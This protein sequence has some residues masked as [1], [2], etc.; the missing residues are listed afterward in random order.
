MVTHPEP[1]DITFRFLVA[2]NSVVGSTLQQLDIGS[3]PTEKWSQSPT[4]Q[5]ADAW[6]R[7]YRETFEVEPRGRIIWLYLYIK[8]RIYA[9]TNTADVDERI[10]GRNKDGDWGN[11]SDELSTVNLSAAGPTL[12]R[13]TRGYVSPRPLSLDQQLNRQPFEIE[14]EARTNETDSLTLEVSSES[15]VRVVY[16]EE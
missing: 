5:V 7:M 8:Y 9:R 15:Y 4:S 6:T 1:R 10:R 14:I 13:R 2:P 12:I 16:E 11:I 3:D